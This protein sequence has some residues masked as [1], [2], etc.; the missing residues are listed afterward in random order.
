MSPQAKYT[1]K[2]LLGTLGT[3][4]A[5]LLTVVTATAKITTRFNV[6]DADHVAITTALNA[7]VKANANETA[8]SKANDAATSQAI[9]SIEKSQAIIA[10]DVEHIRATVEDIKRKL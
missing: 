3:V 4:L 2:W 1:T 6:N 5:M 10:T 9:Q 7:E 8:R